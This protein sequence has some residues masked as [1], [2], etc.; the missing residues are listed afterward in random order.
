[1]YLLSTAGGGRSDSEG[2]LDNASDVGGQKEKVESLLM[3]IGINTN[4]NKSTKVPKGVGPWRTLSS[5]L[6][7][8]RENGF[9]CAQIVVFHSRCEFSHGCVR[10]I[11]ASSLDSTTKGHSAMPPEANIQSVMRQRLSSM[12]VQGLHSCDEGSAGFDERNS[13]AATACATCLLPSPRRC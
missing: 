5:F 7:E 2:S 6:T 10:R 11:L 1:M 13:L 9:P 12:E 8:R 3:L 4:R